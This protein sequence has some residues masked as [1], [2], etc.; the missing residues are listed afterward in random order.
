MWRFQWN[1]CGKSMHSTK[2]KSNGN[3]RKIEREKWLS[4]S[5]N[6]DSECVVCGIA[7]RQ[8][9][10][11]VQGGNYVWC[12]CVCDT[13][14]RSHLMKSLQYAYQRYYTLTNK[15]EIFTTDIVFL[16]HTHSIFQM[17][18]CE[19]IQM[20]YGEYW[21]GLN[22][23]TERMKDRSEGRERERWECVVQGSYIVYVCFHLF[24]CQL[25]L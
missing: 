2:Q 24:G 21:Q 9:Q 3:R 18:K 11:T 6:L 17:P 23:S 12:V 8:T 20:T 14:T 25:T 5:F 19:N 13:M 10:K 7:K 15:P 22:M 1:V 16:I 4:L